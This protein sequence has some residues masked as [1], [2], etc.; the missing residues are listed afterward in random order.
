MVLP[1]CPCCM[2]G[3][4]RTGYQVGICTDLWL[5]KVFEKNLF[6]EIQ[7]VSRELRM[8][9]SNIHLRGTS[10]ETVPNTNISGG[11][12]VADLNGL[13]VKVKI[14]AVES[15]SWAPPG[16]IHGWSSEDVEMQSSS[17]LLLTPSWW[18]MCFPPASGSVCV[19]YPAALLGRKS[20]PFPPS[21]LTSH[22]SFH[23]TQKHLCVFHRPC[24]G[25][26]ATW[27]QPRTSCQ[28]HYKA[29]SLHLSFIAF[30][31][32]FMLTEWASH[33]INLT[34]PCLKT[35]ARGLPTV[36]LL[37]P[38][39]LAWII[40]PSPWS[41]V[42]TSSHFK[43]TP[44]KPFTS[45]LQGSVSTF[46]VSHGPPNKPLLWHVFCGFEIRVCLKLW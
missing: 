40:G 46:S 5:T 10:T 42:K 7:V 38:N 37:S 15:K 20:I 6:S 39:L 22:R 43:P 17:Y 18:K 35:A 4:L 26:I 9:I 24:S 31:S 27:I 23:A 2:Y 14:I 41:V 45:P 21:L 19:Q 29:L 13:A 16:Q 12:V 28:D 3:G 44:G 33:K 36:F 32:G 25:N 8:P 11:S 30:H 34:M 1:T